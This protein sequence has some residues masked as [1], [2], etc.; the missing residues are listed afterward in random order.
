ML[1]SFFAYS[2]SFSL[3]FVPPL[4]YS[5]VYVCLSLKTPPSTLDY[6]ILFA[7]EQRSFEERWIQF[8]IHAGNGGKFLDWT[9]ASICSIRYRN[10]VVRREK[11]QDS[12][13]CIMCNGL[14]F[15]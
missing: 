15:Y 4:V 14:Y 3:S 7:I 6:S 11:E 5:H 8:D 1:N 2:H 13:D 9:R 10:G 12:V